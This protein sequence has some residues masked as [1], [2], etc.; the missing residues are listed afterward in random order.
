MG[1]AH[2][3]L[4]EGNKVS[5]WTKGNN[6]DIGKGF[7]F[8]MTND[9]NISLDSFIRNNKNS[10]FIFDDS[11]FGKIQD[12]ARKEGLKVIGSSSFGEDIEKDR[13]K[14]IEVCE[15]LKIKI[16]ETAKVSN[17]N[18]AIKHIKSNPDRYILKQTG[19]LPKS[20]NWSAECDDS[21]DTI[22]H[23]ENIK[24]H[25][26]FLDGQLVLQKMVEGVEIAVGAWF[27]K[28]DWI[29]QDGKILIEINFENKKLLDGDRGISTGE[30]GTGV[31]FT[32]GENELFKKTLKPLTDIL[33]SVNHV[34]NVDA[35]CIINDKNIYLLEHTIRFGYPISDLYIEMLN[36]DLGMFFKKLADGDLDGY[37]FDLDNK[38]IVLAYAFPNY[39]YEKSKDVYDNFKGETIDMSK[40][41]DEQIDSIHYSQIMKKGES[42]CIADSFGYAMNITGKGKTFDEAN[43]FCLDII[44][45]LGMSKKAFYRTD[46]SKCVTERFNN[47][48]IKKYL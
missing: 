33:K 22:W 11:S 45:N 18:E 48:I 26:G 25:K 5:I 20:L 47:E 46:I 21:R 7:D 37:D 9:K 28:T 29:K 23:L 32:T 16:P 3:L 27:N 43:K 35:N 42:I 17:I 38:G 8:T 39:P 14:G 2:R 12:K 36:E 19:D 4:F 30:L 44:E 1:I 15:S 41:T 34:G 6:S 13:L 40:I 24:Q 31:Y 10:I